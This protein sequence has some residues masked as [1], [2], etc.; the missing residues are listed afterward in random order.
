DGDWE[1]VELGGELDL[2]LGGSGLLV[3]GLEYPQRV[4]E[5]TP[6]AVAVL[7]SALPELRE[8]IEQLVGTLPPELTQLLQRRWWH[9][10][11]R[12]PGLRLG[13]L[14]R[15][16]GSITF[17]LE[18]FA[19]GQLLGLWRVHCPTILDLILS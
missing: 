14:S 8:A 2:R 9:R 7:R 1:I 12:P 6:V 3:T 17:A 11:V 13:E 5:D 15:R 18:V 16:L 4:E 10:L 19:A